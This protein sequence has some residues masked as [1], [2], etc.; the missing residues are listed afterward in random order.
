MKIF[1]CTDSIVCFIASVDE[2]EMAKLPPDSDKQQAEVTAVQDEDGYNWG[3]I[4]TYLG[5][6]YLLLCCLCMC[7]FLWVF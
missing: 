3:Y 5:V 7:T 4:F 6:N 2:V 1:S